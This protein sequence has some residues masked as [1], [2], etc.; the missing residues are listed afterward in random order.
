MKRFDAFVLVGMTVFCAFVIPAAAQQAP[1]YKQ[2]HGDWKVQC[3]RDAMSD[4]PT[5]TLS[6]GGFAQRSVIGGNQTDIAVWSQNKNASPAISIWTPYLLMPQRGLTFRAD[7]NEPIH[8]SCD[9]INGQQCMIMGMNRD[10]LLAEWRSAR[11]LVVR[12]YAFSQDGPDYF[13]DMSGFS[14]GLS[15][16]TNVVSK[17]L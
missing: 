9:S 2:M 7:T 4:K 1:F 14:D 10:R 3:T 6:A 5:C 12:G 11:K 13:F 15:D 16:F 17:N 8:V